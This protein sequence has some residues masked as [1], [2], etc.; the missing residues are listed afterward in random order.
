MQNEREE[1]REE[2]EWLFM[3]RQHNNPVLAIYHDN[4]YTPYFT[5]T[6]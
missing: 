4:D 6:Q 3:V 2:E 1:E 5:L